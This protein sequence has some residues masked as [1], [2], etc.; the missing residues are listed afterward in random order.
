MSQTLTLS[1]EQIQQLIWAI[2]VTEN[3]LEDL[4]EADLQ[5]MQINID[6][7]QLFALATTLEQLIA[8]KV[9]A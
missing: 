5:R 2:D 3:A 6:R 9:E 8:E 7:K 1:N 4:T